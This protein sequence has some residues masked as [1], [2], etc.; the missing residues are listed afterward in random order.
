[1]SQAQGMSEEEQ[2][3][4]A[5]QK[6]QTTMPKTIPGGMGRDG[7]KE[8]ILRDQCEKVVVEAIS[9]ENVAEGLFKMPRV[10][11]KTPEKKGK[12]KDEGKEGDGEGGLKG[13]KVCA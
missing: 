5:K 10:P 2:V 11:R 4:G 9:K 1:M 8:G 3:G 12:A 13:N 7:P 6:Y